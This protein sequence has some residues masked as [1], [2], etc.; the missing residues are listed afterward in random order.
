MV[1]VLIHPTLFLYALFITRVCTRGGVV[2]VSRIPKRPTKVEEIEVLYAFYV[3]TICG[4]I[5]EW[6]DI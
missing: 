6:D 5:F 1:V 2:G 4:A 3:R